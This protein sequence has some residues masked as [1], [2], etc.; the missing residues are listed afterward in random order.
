MGPLKA[1]QK[2]GEGMVK[3]RAEGSYILYVWLIMNEM[4]DNLL[5]IGTGF[6]AKPFVVVSRPQSLRSPKH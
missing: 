6:L 1:K 2:G 4:L 5:F 3:D